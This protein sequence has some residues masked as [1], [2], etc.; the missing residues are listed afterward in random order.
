MAKKRELIDVVMDILDILEK[1]GYE[2]DSW[3]DD[4]TYQFWLFNKEKT[5]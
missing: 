4:D 3:T 5:E 1:S 2:S